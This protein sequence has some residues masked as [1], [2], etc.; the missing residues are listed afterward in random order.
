M[1]PQHIDQL[2]IYRLFIN[3]LNLNLD[4]KLFSNTYLSCASSRVQKIISESDLAK[5]RCYMWYLYET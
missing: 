2:F 4:D 1:L 5:V 3:K